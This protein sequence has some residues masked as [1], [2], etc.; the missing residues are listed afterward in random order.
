M[1]FEQACSRCD[2]S[3]DD[4]HAKTGEP[5]VVFERQPPC[6]A[7]AVQASQTGR[8]VR[9]QSRGNQRAA[10]H[11]EHASDKGQCYQFR[12]QRGDQRAR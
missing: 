8:N 6:D 1:A 9:Q 11:P 4:R 2:Q 10:E 3:P 12:K 5:P 7:G